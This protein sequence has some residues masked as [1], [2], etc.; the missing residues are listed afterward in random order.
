M[1]IEIIIPQYHTSALE[2]FCGCSHHTL[3]ETQGWKP[4]RERSLK[5]HKD[6]ESWPPEN[7]SKILISLKIEKGYSIIESGGK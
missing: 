6:I 3:R 5:W 2:I 1:E 7:Q 4:S